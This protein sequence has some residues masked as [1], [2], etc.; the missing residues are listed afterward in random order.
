MP[1][2]LFLGR[3]QERDET[4]ILAVGDLWPGQPNTLIVIDPAAPS[5]HEI[6][7]ASGVVALKAWA[8]ERDG[9]PMYS[10]PHGTVLLEV[11]PED[12]RSR[13]DRDAT[14]RDRRPTRPRPCA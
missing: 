7:P 14:Q 4:R 2:Q 11:L 6:T 12:N 3:L 1:N 10:Y 9:T 13:A 8:L 5:W